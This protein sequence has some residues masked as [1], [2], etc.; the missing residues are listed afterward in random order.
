MSRSKPTTAVKTATPSDCWRLADAVLG[1]CDRVL[2][3]GPSGTGKTL[4]ALTQGLPP[5][6]EAMY[7]VLT[8]DTPAAEIRGMFVPRDG[9]FVWQ[10][11][12]AVTAWRRGT[13]LVLDEID[14]AS[15]EVMTL[16]MAITDSLPTAR[17]SLPTCETVR[18]A[19]G[20]SVI[21]TMNGNPD[22]LPPALRDRF[23]VA[24]E[25]DAVHPGAL[26]TLPVDV[27]EAASAT[28]LLPPERRL[29]VRGWKRFAGL[30]D[31]V[32]AQ[33]A[34][35]AVFGR[36]RAGDVLDALKLAAA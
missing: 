33:D 17:L 24:I 23:P 35:T 13:R 1:H 25:I 22:H 30:R 21:A 26:A 28:A 3:S 27:R 6:Q 34:A 9:A 29:S 36:E 20:F 5:G 19:A 31:V 7:S 14:H 18:P 16:L 2:L 11:G 8:E 4:W 10:D 32:G 15:G 12:P